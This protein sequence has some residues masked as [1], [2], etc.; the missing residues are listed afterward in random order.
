MFSCNQ[1]FSRNKSRKSIVRV[2]SLYNKCFFFSIK[3]FCKLIPFWTV[4]SAFRHSL[5]PRKQK[6]WALLESVRKVDMG[7]RFRALRS[8]LKPS[9]VSHTFS[10][11]GGRGGA[12]S[13]QLG[14]FKYHHP[15]IFLRTSWQF[16][17]N[18]IDKNK[19]GS[20]V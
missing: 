8:I 20:S 1:N 9:G 16:S 15:E 7:A 12:L 17:N 19:Q 6:T 18:L 4:T 11:R 5:I 14:K 10:W 13:D 2:L 3:Y